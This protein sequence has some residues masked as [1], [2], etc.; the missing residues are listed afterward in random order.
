MAGAAA[1]P[2]RSPSRFSEAA[3]SLPGGAG[4]EGDAPSL[5]RQ[6]FSF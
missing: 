5:S 6:G 1:N 4:G 2:S 3:G